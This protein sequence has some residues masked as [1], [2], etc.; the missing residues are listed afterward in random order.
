MGRVLSILLFCSLLLGG[1]VFASEPRIKVCVNSSNPSVACTAAQRHSMARAAGLMAVSDYVDMSGASVDVYV[2]NYA[3][4]L[5]SA[6]T[7]SGRVEMVRGEDRIVVTVV[8]L[9]PDYSIVSN[10]QSA[11]RYMKDMATNGI[12]SS[13]LAWNYEHERPVTSAHQLGNQDRAS[14]LQQAL[15]RTLSNNRDLITRTGME[16]IKNLA[17]LDWTKAVTIKFPDGTVVQVKLVGIIDDNDAGISFEFEIIPGTAKDGNTSIPTTAGGFDGVYLENM[18]GDQL[19]RFLNTARMLNIPI[20]SGG[21]G[22]RMS[23]RWDGQ[24]ITCHFT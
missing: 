23:C 20:T 19:E 22:G 1:E 13:T 2:F 21:G 5:V 6:Y 10:I 8:A 14:Q 11:H 3:D 18:Q 7:V 17:G 16:V 15:S 9:A 24:T 12:S 4:G